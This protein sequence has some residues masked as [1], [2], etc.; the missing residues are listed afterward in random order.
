MGLPLVRIGC[1]V[2]EICRDV[3]RVLL[4]YVALVGML[5]LFMREKGTTQT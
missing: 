2:G 4:H 1:R 5:M 3:V